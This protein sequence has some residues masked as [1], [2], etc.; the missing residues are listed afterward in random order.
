[1]TVTL[2]DRRSLDLL[3]QTLA[4]LALAGGYGYVNE[5]LGLIKEAGGVKKFKDLLEAMAV[6][7]VDSLLRWGTGTTVCEGRGE[8][9]VSQCSIS[10]PSFTQ[11]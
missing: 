8:G 2:P 9:R 11:S 6:P 10:S 4:G 5:L 3:A 7:G 1:V